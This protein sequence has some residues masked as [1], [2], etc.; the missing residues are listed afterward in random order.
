MVTSS[1]LRY[2]VLALTLAAVVGCRN[3]TVDFMPIVLNTTPE[4]G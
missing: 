1:P 4:Q 3:I 2:S